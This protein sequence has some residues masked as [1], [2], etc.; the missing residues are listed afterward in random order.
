MAVKIVVTGNAVEAAL[1][2]DPE[3][4]AQ[5]NTPLGRRSILAAVAAIG[6]RGNRAIGNAEYMT[7]F[8]LEQACEAEGVR[9]FVGNRGVGSYRQPDQPR[10]DVTPN[11]TASPEE[12]RVAFDLAVEAYTSH[13]NALADLVLGQLK[14]Q[15]APVEPTGSMDKGTV[16]ADGGLRW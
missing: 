2:A 16:T 12:L 1:Q 13:M 3:L 14:A 8:H 15:Q 7:R 11:P 6:N 10:V 5:W 4:E 9:A